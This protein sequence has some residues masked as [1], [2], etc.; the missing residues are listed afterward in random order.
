MAR[1]LFF[2][3]QSGAPPPRDT[4]AARL[5][6]ASS[7]DD[8]SAWESLGMGEISEAAL[9]DAVSHLQRLGWGF[10]YEARQ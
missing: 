7:V 3:G 6:E 9:E 1:E 5:L 2:A 4:L 10:Y 8:E